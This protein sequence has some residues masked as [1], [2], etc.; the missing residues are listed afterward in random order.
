[1]FSFFPF[2]IH[3]VSGHSMQPG[4]KE[5]S[6]VVVFRW[7]YAF[8][9]PKVGDV[10]VLSSSDGKS[11]VKRITAAVNKKEFV[12]KGDN[13]SDSKKLPPTKKEAIIGKV[14]AKY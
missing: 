4:L 12:V 8:S 11:Y 6:R 3:I 7:S 13:K 5:G 1:M 2:S 9:Q 14:V 10:V